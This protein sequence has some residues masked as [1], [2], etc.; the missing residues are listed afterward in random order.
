MA[1][2]GRDPSKSGAEVTK[3]VSASVSAKQIASELE[4]VRAEL[5]SRKHTATLDAK[6]GVSKK[7]SKGGADAHSISLLEPE[8]GA[9]SRPEKPT[10]L[11]GAEEFYEP[12]RGRGLKATKP[13]EPGDVVLAEGPFAAVLLK[14]RRENNCHH[15]FAAV[16]LNPVPCSGCAGP[17][18]CQEKCRDNAVGKAGVDDATSK[19][20]GEGNDVTE[21]RR[22]DGRSDL[23]RG[24]TDSS[25]ETFVRK[26][27]D[28]GK[29]E[30]GNGVN[31]D[32]FGVHAHE[33][34]GASWAAILPPDAVLAVRMLAKLQRERAAR[35]DGPSADTLGALKVGQSCF[36]RKHFC[37][38]AEASHH[39]V[40]VP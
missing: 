13:F 10:L 4:K 28:I 25:D 29:A 9:E 37:R 32:C 34:G 6:A 24:I 12:G 16:P 36:F 40:A 7:A 30:G 14:Y 5:A 33:C 18:F 27:S 20:T 1:N 3:G 22:T 39:L 26:V 23:P 38:H 31:S 15:C 8:S 17:L 35:K 19:G 21:R 2:E 11:A